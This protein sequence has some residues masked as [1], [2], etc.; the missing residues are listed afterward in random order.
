VKWSTLLSVDDSDPDFRL[1]ELALRESEISV[2][3]YRVTDGEQAIAFLGRLGEFEDAPRPDLILL[4]ISMPKR[5][6]FEVLQYLKSK[7][8]LRSI[9]VV[10]FTTSSNPRE[11]Q[12]VLAMG[13]EQFI[14]KSSH[15]DRFIDDVQTA[16]ARHL[17]ISRH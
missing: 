11:K 10:I 6:G 5:N 4:D 15:L 2:R 17:G 9:P 13:A 16:C 1:I 3:L 12:R 7:D 8:S 14:S